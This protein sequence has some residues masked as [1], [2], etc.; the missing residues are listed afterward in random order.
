MKRIIRLTESDLT[1][2]IKRVISEKTETTTM[3]P[4]FYTS[5]IGIENREYSA[6]YASG[7]DVKFKVEA[8]PQKLKDNKGNM[9]VQPG[10]LG[11]RITMD[12]K[13]DTY[14]AMAY[15]CNTGTM[16][17]ATGGSYDTYTD[18]NFKSTG[19]ES[20]FDTNSAK[21]WMSQSMYGGTYPNKGAIADMTSKYCSSVKV[22]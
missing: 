5:I 20:N 17:R 8:Y 3:T 18:I 4:E 7:A 22:K 15:D 19:R 16:G 2:I 21:N 9:V 6:N 14:A 12:G 10:K 11:I 13:P 1:R